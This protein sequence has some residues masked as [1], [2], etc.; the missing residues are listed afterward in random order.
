MLAE[1]AKALATASLPTQRE[2]VIR[3]IDRCIEKAARIALT[4]TNIQLFR[5]EFHSKNANVLY[6]VPLDDKSMQIYLNHFSDMGFDIGIVGDELLGERNPVI[7]HI[8]WEGALPLNIF[9]A[10]TSEPQ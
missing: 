3:E 9:P 8:S 1:E 5:K 4:S 7:L 10:A 6:G 2:K